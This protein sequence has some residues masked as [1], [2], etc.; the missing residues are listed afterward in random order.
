MQ[1][2]RFF[3]VD[4]AGSVIDDRFIICADDTEACEFADDLVTRELGIEVW[5]VGRQVF[6][7]SS[8]NVRR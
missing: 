4:D 8:A 2:Y 3:S 5:D 6:K 1:S 7:A